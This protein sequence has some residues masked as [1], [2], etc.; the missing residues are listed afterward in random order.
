MACH[1]NRGLHR[2]DQDQDWTFKTKTETQRFKTKTWTLKTKTE[3][4]TSTFESR[5]VSR[6]RL[7]SREL[8]HW[9]RQTG[10]RSRSIERTVTCNWRPKTLSDGRE[11]KRVSAIPCSRCIVRSSKPAGVFKAK[12]RTPN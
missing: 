9:D 6:P 4:E 7:E 2:R 3:T 12:S 10:Q 1:Q 8:H 5:D 11:G